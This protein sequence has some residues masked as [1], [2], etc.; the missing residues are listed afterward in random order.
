MTNQNNSLLKFWAKT[1]HDK[2]TY[3]NA[4]HPLIC[5]LIDV[6]VVTKKMWKEV[7]PKATK[8]RINKKFGV[9]DAGNFIAFIAGLHDL[10]KCSPPF[11][12]RGIGIENKVSQL[13]KTLEMEIESNSQFADKTYGKLQT[14]YLL[15][16][17]KNTPYWIKNEKVSP[18]KCAPH[19]YVTAVELPEILQDVKFG[20]NKEFAEQIST[21]IGGHHGTF[22][23]CEWK[24]IKT[25]YS[26][27][28]NDD[29]K[30]ART[31]LV[32]K[33]S[34]LFK[35]EPISHTKYE[36]LDNGTIMILAGL[37]SVADWIGSDT[38][39]FK[40]AAEYFKDEVT[41]KICVKDDF[42]FDL[43]KYKKRAESQAIK[44]LEDLGWIS[45][46]EEHE[47]EGD[48]TR[49]FYD[50]FPELKKH[51][52]RDLQ[53]QAVAISKKLDKP[54]IV[55]IES[56]TGEGKTEAAMFLA[57]AWNA[58]LKQHGYYFALPTQAT[59]DQ[60]FGRVLKFLS[61]RYENELVSAHLA[62]GKSLDNTD[63]ARIRENRKKIKEVLEKGHQSLAEYFKEQ[64]NGFDENEIKGIHDENDHD[65]DC[66]PNV[67]AAEWFTHR[68]RSL[69]VPFGIGTIDQALMAVLQTRHVFVR[70]FGLAHKTVIIDEV[71]AYDA[72]MS[73]LLERLLEWL[74]ALGSPVI[75][76][77]ATLP[78]STRENLIS[79]YLKGLGKEKPEFETG[80]YPR[81]SYSIDE[82]VKVKEIGTSK[83]NDRTLRIEKINEILIKQEDN[84]YQLD[85]IFVRDLK[86]KLTD[87]DGNKKGCVAI[88]CNTV[89][90]S[91]E[92]YN[93]L[94]KDEFFTDG[95]DSGIDLLHARFR[96]LDKENKKDAA[97]LRFGKK[98][99]TV[100]ILK[101]GKEFN[102]TV[103][104]PVC[105][106][107]VSTQIIE[108]SLDLDFDLM[109]SD[110]APIDLLLQRAGRIKRHSRDERPENF[111]G[112]AELWI[113]K[114]PLDENEN[115]IADKK[116]KEI[117]LPDFGVSG[118][119]YDKHILLRTWMQI[120][121]IEE[122]KVPSDVED[123]I[124]AVYCKKTECP[125]EE[126]QIFWQETKY[127]M[128]E[129]RRRKN[130]K[131]KNNR[132]AE[133]NEEKLFELR[134]WELDED[135]PEKHKVHQA[136]TRDDELPSV[137]V[138]ILTHEE[139]RQVDFDKKPEEKM[140]KFLLKREARITKIGLTNEIIDA[141]R[142]KE[143]SW[144][145]SPQLRHYR[146]LPL[147]EK[148]EFKIG[149]YTI[150]L[151]KDLGIIVDQEKKDG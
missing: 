98:G 69:L 65:Y 143:N 111:K 8:D 104:R 86:E 139:Q 58:M 39:F 34:K 7:L 3:P 40:C 97:L 11:A 135:D 52:I 151:N 103:K 92:I 42:D 50:L 93:A 121:K 73:T 71:H 129:N 14:I 59:S 126:F 79:N 141:E 127:E 145:Q 72:Y 137:S 109:I 144:K 66:T 108:Q 120:R 100:R 13:K 119:I 36:K 132:I 80:D 75:L 78:K 107:L 45:I 46:S 117:E 130:D 125:D 106:V 41:Q 47:T 60:M 94:S 91:Q 76:L 51:E 150:S 64:R 15:E 12:L 25:D 67:V 22:P 23:G 54:G 77:S 74:A 55:I 18:V 99:E 102:E 68:K 44:A 61:R 131:A 110:L 9:E 90:R 70:L 37:V 20:F 38:K 82:Q 10:G 140:T 114:P 142:L 89:A 113:I 30:N 81:I 124:E 33:L 149:K 24:D 53:A 146:Y 138:I 118:I 4:Y 56:P 101:N 1:S 21:L 48:Q 43:N 116:N 133:T 26:K 95:E 6:A 63:S 29:W 2:D 49:S 123:F 16:L 83:Q 17:Y 84:T 62:H 19:G 134:S 57:D 147:D 128:K 87:K 85:E 112:N 32:E 136:L 148:G 88:I 31:D 115:L 27:V 105:A 96:H 28:G 35:A 122:I 5:H